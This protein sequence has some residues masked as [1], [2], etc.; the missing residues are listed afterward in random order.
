MSE[1]TMNPEP[2]PG[3]PLGAPESREPREYGDREERA[4]ENGSQGRT[5]DPV[6]SWAQ[7]VAAHGT[8]P[9][10][11]VAVDVTVTGHPEPLP[12][13]I[14]L[15]DARVLHSMLGDA[16]RHHDGDAPGQPAVAGALDDLVTYVA[17]PATGE[18]ARA[19]VRAE[20]RP[21]LARYVEAIREPERC[22]PENPRTELRARCAAALRAA[23]HDCDGGCGLPEGECVAR[24]PIQVAAYGHGRVEVVHGP[25]EAL[26]DVMAAV[27]DAELAEARADV[28]RLRRAVGEV[29]RFAEVHAASCRVPVAETARDLLRHL[30]R[31]LDEEADRG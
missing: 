24:H 1:P 19:Q 22:L 9:A 15:A 8:G 2:A 6:V 11:K 27:H 26:A 30:D 20:L 21:Y 4:R 5:G 3:K 31:A 29:R 16:I 23:A 18:R 17:C 7:S 10:A 28:A 14:P 13:E 12:M 25:V